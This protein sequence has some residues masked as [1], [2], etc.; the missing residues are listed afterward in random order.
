MF[1]FPLCNFSTHDYQSEGLGS[2]SGRPQ[3]S[4]PD[5]CVL[6]NKLH[7]RLHDSHIF[8]H[9]AAYCSSLILPNP[10]NTSMA[11]FLTVRTAI[12]VTNIVSVPTSIF[13]LQQLPHRRP[14]GSPLFLR[15][16]PHLAKIATINLELPFSVSDETTKL[17]SF[18]LHQS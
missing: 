14:V 11:P 10:S 16:Q 15:I 6:R 1:L 13:F 12:A 7:T 3:L 9:T 17:F 5:C 18:V 4:A 2:I 8:R